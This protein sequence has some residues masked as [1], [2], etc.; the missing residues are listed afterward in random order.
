MTGA[1]SSANGTVG[2]VNAT[3]PKDG[4]NT[5]FL[6]ADGTWSVPAYPTKASWNYDDVYLKL[7]GGSIEGKLSIKK[8]L[9]GDLTDWVQKQHDGPFEVGRSTN[10]MCVAIGV[11]DDNYGYIQVKGGNITTPGNLVILPGG[12]TL[13]KGN[14]SIVILDSSNSS[15]SKSGETLTV[16]IGGTSY[17]LTNTW[18]GI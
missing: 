12:G 1:T 14:T 10:S 3:P 17:S 9:G 8:D 6:R 2:Y 7:S 4:Y 11:T 15:V 13:Y 5:K 16:N 18:R